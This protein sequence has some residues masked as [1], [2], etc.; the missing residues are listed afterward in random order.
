M[1][2]S[3]HFFMGDAL[4][5]D[6]NRLWKRDAMGNSLIRVILT[7]LTYIVTLVP[8]AIAAFFIVIFL[9]G[10]HAGILPSWLE[11]VV[12]ILAWLVVFVVP[13]LVAHGVWR[14]WKPS[15]TSAGLGPDD[16]HR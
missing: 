5:T 9:A 16:D 7:I 13:G 10:P 15:K 12:L 14:R 11:S 2:H 3:R 6:Q 4:S 1:L 8:V